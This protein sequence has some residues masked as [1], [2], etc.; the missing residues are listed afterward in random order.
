MLDNPASIYDRIGGF[1]TIDRLVET[2]YR[3]M[4]ALPEARG[5]SRLALRVQSASSDL[6]RI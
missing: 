3:N 2:F 6:S 1:D 4:D 5:I